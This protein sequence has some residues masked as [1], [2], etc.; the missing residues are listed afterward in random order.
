MNFHDL[1]DKINQKQAA[2]K[3]KVLDKLQQGAGL[4]S[5]NQQGEGL[6]HD[7]KRL[8]YIWKSLEKI[9]H[10]YSG[11]M[12][13]AERQYILDKFAEMREINSEIDK[14]RP[15]TR[16]RAYEPRL[17]ALERDYLEI[18]NNYEFIS[19]EDIM[20]MIYNLEEKR[21]KLRK[22]L[23]NPKL[24]PAVISQ[25]QTQLAFLDDKYDE[26]IDGLKKRET[27]EELDDLFRYKRYGLD[28]GESDE[29]KYG[30]ELKDEPNDLI[31]RDIQNELRELLEDRQADL[32][33]D[34]Y[35][36]W[37]EKNLDPIS[38]RL[39]Q[40]YKKL[41]RRMQIKRNHR[42]K[43]IKAQIKEKFKIRR[44]RIEESRKL[45]EEERLKKADE[46]LK[47]WADKVQKTESDDFPNARTKKAMENL[48]LRHMALSDRHVGALVDDNAVKGMAKRRSL[49][50]KT[51]REKVHNINDLYV[52]PKRRRRSPSP[53]L[54][55][56]RTRSEAAAADRAAAAAARIAAARAASGA[57]RGRSAGRR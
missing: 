4:T 55:E 19:S 54:I 35:A 9:W 14:T 51:L 28:L 37:A 17:A 29:E 34:A 56:G 15:K 24:S 26:F 22:K 42:F 13:P 39:S 45:K 46:T 3:Q 53:P 7:A 1:K 10:I 30:E 25:Y 27:T 52:L 43:I 57:R 16:N 44:E 49:S 11:A 2:F 5:I 38:K 36:D 48:R 31:P 8:D 40:K 33:D 18:R 50:L 12:L 47:K 32:E 6:R 20:M 21:D 23:D 41:R